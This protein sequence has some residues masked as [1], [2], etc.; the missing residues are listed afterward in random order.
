[1]ERSRRVYGRGVAVV[2]AAL[3]V[4]GV[5]S[6]IA[7]TFN[8]SNLAERT[9]PLRASAW[10]AL[11]LHEPSPA[12]RRQHV[13]NLEARYAARPGWIA[14][15]ASLG[16][17]FLLLG[18]LQFVPRIRKRHIHLHR[19]N[20]RA[21]LAVGGIVAVTGMYFGIV[22][23]AAGNREATVIALVSAFF[24]VSLVS[25]GLAIRRKDLRA[26]R[27]WMIRAFAVAIGISTVRIVAVVA[28][29]T[30][31]PRG[32][33]LES[34]FV[35]SLVLGWGVTVGAAELWIIHTRPSF[36]PLVQAGGGQSGIRPAS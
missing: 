35:L 33:P 8:P 22:I 1:M 29:A 16:A 27:E 10:Q 2:V 4:M 30:L 6:G 5:A 18:F 12:T 19:W 25:G 21:L 7:R 15:H 31:S 28:D 24:L 36:D 14:F 20:G 11:D 9:E 17:L 3:V 23:P 34:V 32:W 26:H 13:R